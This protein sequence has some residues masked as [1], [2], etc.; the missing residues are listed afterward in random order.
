MTTY[1]RKFHTYGLIELAKGKVS[2]VGLLSK[3][4]VHYELMYN[5]ELAIS[6]LIKK[7]YAGT[8]KTI[9]L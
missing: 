6:N 1:E 3:F 2:I 7:I 4:N 9:M 8:A 5:A